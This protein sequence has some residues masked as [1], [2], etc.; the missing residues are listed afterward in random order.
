MISGPSMTSNA[1]AWPHGVIAVLYSVSSNDS[2]EHH[3]KTINFLSFVFL[4]FSTRQA[5]LLSQPFT[6]NQLLFLLT[7]I[8]TLQSYILITCCKSQASIMLKVD[9]E[10]ELCSKG[11]YISNGS[12]SHHHQQAFCLGMRVGRAITKKCG[13]GL[14]YEKPWF[15]IF[16]I[17]TCLLF[18]C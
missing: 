14:G 7:F 18:H 8:S 5:L 16:T 6:F 4:V 17:N 10:E 15:N 3:Q 11:H 9:E 13:K 2:R 12:D 1:S